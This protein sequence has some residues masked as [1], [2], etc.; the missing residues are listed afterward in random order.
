MLPALSV[1]DQPGNVVGATSQTSSVIVVVV[2]GTTGMAKALSLA[3]ANV[4]A[5]TWT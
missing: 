3:L 4:V 5:A 1:P 2:G